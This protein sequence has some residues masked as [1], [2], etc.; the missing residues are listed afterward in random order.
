MLLPITFTQRCLCLRRDGVSRVAGSCRA[1]HPV[2][3]GVISTPTI[4]QQRA[5]KFLAVSHGPGYLWSRG[6]R[7]ARHGE[8]VPVVLR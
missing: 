2:R 8:A 6:E 5:S 1:L 7:E 3:A 4:V